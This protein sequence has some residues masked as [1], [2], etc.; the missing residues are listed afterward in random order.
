[1][2]QERGEERQGGRRQMGGWTGLSFKRREMVLGKEASRWHLGQASSSSKGVIDLTQEELKRKEKQDQLSQS[3]STAQILENRDQERAMGT[4][5]VS[6]Y[7]DLK[8]MKQNAEEMAISLEQKIEDC[9]KQVD[10]GKI[11]LKDFKVIKQ[12]D[13]EA[14]EKVKRVLQKLEKERRLLEEKLMARTDLVSTCADLS[15]NNL[16]ID[17]R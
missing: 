14:V 3:S 4:C 8:L 6:S 11:R 2:R 16:I 1:M 9:R 10:E 12:A 15:L 17:F 7:G 13:M 5:G